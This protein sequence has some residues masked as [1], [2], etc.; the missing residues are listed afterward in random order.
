MVEYIPITLYKLHTNCRV[1]KNTWILKKP[2]NSEFK[3]KKNYEQTGILKKN[4]KILKFK[5]I[6][7]VKWIFEQKS[8][9]NLK[10]LEL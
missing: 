9:K 4:Q 2:R 3:Q 10:K 8:L 1:A 6:W 5:K 7:K